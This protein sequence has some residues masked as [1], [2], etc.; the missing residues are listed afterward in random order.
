MTDPLA[1]DRLAGLP[2]PTPFLVL[3]LDRVAAA[4]L[5]SPQ[6]CPVWRPLRD[7]VQ[8]GPRGS[9]RGCTGSAA[10]SRSP[11]CRARA[12]AELGV[13]PADVLYSN[14]VKPLA[15]IA[16]AW[17][18]GCGGSPFD[19]EASWTSSP[20]TPRAARV[21]R[22]ARRSAAARAQRGQVRGQHGTG[23]RAAARPP[24][25]PGCGR[26]ALAFHV[27]SQMLHPARAGTPRCG[28]P[29]PCWR[30]AA[31]GIRLEMLDLGGGFPPVRGRPPPPL[32]EYAATIGAGSAGPAVP[33]RRSGIEPG[34][35]LVAEAGVMVATVIGR[36][37]GRP[38]LGA[39]G[40]RCVQRAHGEPGKR[41]RAA[42]PVTD[43]RGWR[44]GE[45]AQLTGPTCDSQDTI[46]FDVPLSVD[47]AVEDRVFLGTAGAYTTSYASA[48]NGFPVPRTYASVLVDA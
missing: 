2:G 43:S 1:A 31:D 22:L 42:F 19:C 28:P 26:T 4:Y 16:A 3:D 8:P 13:D 38:A 23:N 36:P 18:P 15:H 40:R 34:R 9:W 41:Q 32:A 30:A 17:P 29:A 10:G 46:M 37:A 39:P 12:L 33:G 20:R 47:L 11:R 6:R 24:A 35:A 14:P 21:V 5:G 44:G 7:E 27:G 45:P 25:T 48:F